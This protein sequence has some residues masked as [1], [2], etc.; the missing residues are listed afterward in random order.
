[1]C[2]PTTLSMVPQRPHLNQ[3]HKGNLIQALK[4]ILS[5]YSKV[6]TVYLHEYQNWPRG[7]FSVKYPKDPKIKLVLSVCLQNTSQ[8]FLV[9]KVSHFHP[10]LTIP[11]ATSKTSQLY[12]LMPGLTCGSFLF[13]PISSHHSYP[14]PSLDSCCT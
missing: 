11:M 3:P 1:M 13:F 7:H 6:V 2:T 5:Y 12:Y 14:H 4:L 9:Q 8:H 10:L